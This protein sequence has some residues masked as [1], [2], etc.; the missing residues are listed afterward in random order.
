MH[1][2]DETE[3]LQFK[4]WPD[5]IHPWSAWPVYFENKHDQMDVFMSE[6][7]EHELL[8]NQISKFFSVLINLISTISKP[9]MKPGKS[10]DQSDHL[11]FKD[12]DEGMHTS[13]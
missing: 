9:G 6:R 10:P 12:I 3:Q 11:Y 5:V 2:S 1:M 13:D 4:A 8:V 7:P